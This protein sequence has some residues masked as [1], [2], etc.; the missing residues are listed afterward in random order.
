MQIFLLSLG[1]ALFGFII[2]VVILGLFFFVRGFISFDPEE[3]HND[4]TEA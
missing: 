4:F 2:A 3:E 1:Y